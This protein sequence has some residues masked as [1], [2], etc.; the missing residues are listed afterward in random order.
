MTPTTTDPC[1]PTPDHVPDAV[2]AA[3]ES[4][5]A[6]RV[7]Q[8]HWNSADTESASY[9]RIVAEYEHRLAD[10]LGDRARLRV[11][12]RAFGAYLR[13]RDVIAEHI[14]PCVH[15]AMKDVPTVRVL[16]ERGGLGDDIVQWATEGYYGD[17][18]ATDLLA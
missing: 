6:L 13:S 12:M 17:G 18:E 9:H 10:S 8:Q 7:V 14:V 2:D 15:E 16:F 5:S 4:Q 3:V 11:E 1:P